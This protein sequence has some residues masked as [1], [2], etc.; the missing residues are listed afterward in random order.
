MALGKET[1]DLTKTKFNEKLSRI[2]KNF[3]AN[4]KL[5]GEPKEFVLRCC[6]LCDQWSK[7]A[8]D[9]EVLVYLRNI[10][11]AGGRKI[12]MISLE[13]GQTR[14]PVPK[15]KLVN[16]LY[17]VKKTVATATPEEKHY[18]AV[19]AAMRGGIDYQL[20]SFRDSV[21]LPIICSITGK[22]IRKGM[23]TDVDH[24]GHTFSE[25]AD[26]FLRGKDLCYTG[27]TL[28]GP[29]TAKVFSDTILWTEWMEFHESK[30]RYSLVCASAN[31]SKGS[32]GYIT[33]TELYGSFAKEDPEDLSLDF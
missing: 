21:Q 18:N 14:Q 3:R 15:A 22:K 12:K 7:M 19:K 16:A 8:N 17:P 32:D 1:F 10:E 9:P 30:A 13:R 2:I 24:V 28:K 4:S 25:I 29:P 27:I 5:I 31:R 33:P 11:I 23:R 6:K 26:E 20:K